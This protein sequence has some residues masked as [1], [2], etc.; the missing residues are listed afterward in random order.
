MPNSL[1]MVQLQL[2][3]PLL[4]G[5]KD[6]GVDP[7]PVLSSVG[8][9]QN[10]VDQKGASV[11]VMVVHQFVEQ[12]AA[13]SGDRTFCAK[14][15]FTLDTRG[16]PMLQKA[17]EQATTLGEFLNIY[18]VQAAK[19]ASSIT[20]YVEARGDKAT[21][22]ET[23]NFEPLIPPAQNDGF[24]IGLKL[25]ILERVLGAQMKPERVLVVL[26]DPSVLP[27][28]LERYQALRGNNMGT[29]IQFPAEWLSLPIGGGNISSDL[30]D[31]P[32]GNPFDSFLVDFRNLLRQNI[33]NGGLTAAEAAQLAHLGQ[34]SLSRKLNQVGSSISKELAKA[35]LNYAKD[36]LVGSDTSI[37]D[38]ATSLGYSDPSNFSRAFAKEETVT[39]TQ[40]RIGRK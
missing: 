23:R 12:C 29:R 3:V 17:F 13:A 36:A 38:I 27:K 33:S 4:N 32:S 24:G 10:A 14:I 7:E 40:F 16:W 35:K 25:A 6:I 26:S 28:S 9:T 2:L 39:P 1:P 5:L 15:G 37:E 30:N 34:R 19:V 8:L 22:G 20:P 31:S 18:V 21:F 11:H